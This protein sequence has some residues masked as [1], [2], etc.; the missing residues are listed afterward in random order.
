VAL[1][2][3]CGCGRINFDISPTDAITS[4]ADTAVVAPNRAFVVALASPPNALGGVAA[5]DL[6]CAGAAMGAGLAGTYLAYLAT[7]AEP[8][9]ARIAI[10]RGWVRMDGKPIADRAEELTT[11]MYYPVMFDAGGGLATAGV[12]VTGMNRDDTVT[13]TC[14]DYNGGVNFVPCGDAAATAGDFASWGTCACTGIGFAIYC[15]GVDRVAQL[16]APP[17]AVGRRM[18]AL[19]NGWMPGGGI[20]SADAAC[21][22]E[23]A[24][25][26][27]QG[28]FLA[29]LSTTTAP[30]AS[31]F[32]V[33]GP[34]WVR[35]DGVALSTDASTLLGGNTLES[36]PDVAAD[37]SYVSL[38]V[39]TGASVPTA[40]GDA[41]TTC[42][43]WT[44]T[45]PTTP[46]FG[47]TGFSNTGW[48]SISGNLHCNAVGALYCLET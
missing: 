44:S 26:G 2:I 6:L 37:G 1:V 3:L 32:T 25:A 43:D 45:S 46:V 19:K 33:S 41:V 21:V 38:Q 35:L 17:P 22:A 28:T 4:P 40:T 15:F 7:L 34:P 27:L 11:K 29:L 12:V 31:R 39:F 47:D 8:A 36:S 18:F 10:A 23:A 42:S 30:A 48:W 5:A 16:S 24:A 14:N 13:L 20:A 9:P